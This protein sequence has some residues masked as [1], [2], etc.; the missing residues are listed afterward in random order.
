MHIQPEVPIRGDLSG[1][2]AFFSSARA[3]QVLGWRHDQ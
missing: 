2:N 3:E 1:T